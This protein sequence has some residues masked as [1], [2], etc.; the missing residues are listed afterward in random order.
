MSNTVVASPAA[1]GAPEVLGLTELPSSAREYSWEFVERVTKYR[2]TDGVGVFA[3]V[4]T[5]DQPDQLLLIAQ[6]RPPVG[7]FVVEL[8]AGIIEKGESIEQVALRELKEE[9]GYSGVLERVTPEVCNDQGLTNSCLNF[10][11]ATVYAAASENSD[12]QPEP[13]LG[14]TLQ[15]LLLPLVDLAT[16]LLK[17]KQDN[18]WHIDSRLFA[19]ALGLDFAC[20]SS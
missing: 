1:T 13:E 14:E 2:E 10:A 12:P 19:F 17:L 3:K 20:S 9:T 16:E 18:G 8:P 6:Y 7:T 11:F 15:V 4:V 5:K